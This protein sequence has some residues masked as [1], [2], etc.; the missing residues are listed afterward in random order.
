MF[1]CNYSRGNFRRPEDNFLQTNVW[2][3][4]KV[5]LALVAACNALKF[6][7]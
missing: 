1:V 2:K 5:V 6:F 7:Q 4:L 3:F